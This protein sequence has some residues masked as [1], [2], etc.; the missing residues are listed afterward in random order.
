[1][2]KLSFT[3]YLPLSPLLHRLLFCA[4]LSIAVAVGGFLVSSFLT[5]RFFFVCVLVY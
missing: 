3:A 5:S 1:V 4:L 2:L